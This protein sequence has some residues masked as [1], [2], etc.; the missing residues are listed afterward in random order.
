MKK[1]ARPHTKP[2]PV[3][4]QV[5]ARHGISTDFLLEDSQQM[6]LLAA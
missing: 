5:L 1:S 4:D 6:P 3:I 2:W